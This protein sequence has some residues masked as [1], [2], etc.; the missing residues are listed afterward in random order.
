MY[1]A[2]VKEEMSTGG[3]LNCRGQNSKEFFYTKTSTERGKKRA[4]FVHQGIVELSVFPPPVVIGW[5][6]QGVPVW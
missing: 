1:E 6:A 3:Y 4:E 2:L 5:R